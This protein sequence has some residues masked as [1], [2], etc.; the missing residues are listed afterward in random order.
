MVPAAATARLTPV[1]P[2]AIG[3]VICALARSKDGLP[4]GAKVRRCGPG[5][6]QGGGGE[7]GRGCSLGA[8]HVVWLPVRC[9][10][11]CRLLLGDQ[12]RGGGAAPAGERFSSV[13]L[14]FS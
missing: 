6:G 3:S 11:M 14:A 12:G 5:F 8:V 9:G 7:D 13:V 4:E 10:G 2:S 1:I